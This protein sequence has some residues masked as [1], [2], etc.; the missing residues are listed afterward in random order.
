MKYG[1]SEISRIVGGEHLGKDA[2]I[3]GVFVDSRTGVNDSGALFVALKGARHDG[4]RYIG[5]LYA[6]GI[7][8]F[9]VNR[10]FP[11]G[12]FAEAN[13]V[14]AD[15]TLKAMQNLAADY[16]NSFAFPVLGITGSNGKTCVKEWLYRIFRDLETVAR[17]PKSYNSQTG[18]P[19]SVLMTDADAGLGIFEAG[20]SMPDEMERLERILHPDIGIFT[21]TGDAHQENFKSE[22]HKI[23]EKLQL[24]KSSNLLIYCSDYAALHKTVSESEHPYRTFTWG[25][26][27]ECN[28]RILN[29]RSFPDRT[30]LSIEA[31]DS[32]SGIETAKRYEFEIPF[33]DSASVENAMH[34]IAFALIRGV[35]VGLLS[36]KLQNLTPV[37]MRLELKE[38]VNHCTIINDSYNSDVNSLT[39]ALDFLDG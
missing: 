17:S 16:R 35:D 12:D 34:C 29:R 28:L 20:I 19:L 13:F 8:S 4:H 6:K 38:G 37:A 25:Y 14:V 7:R 26:G 1:L 3:T 5:E 18:V 39:I 23:N 21:N 33:S 24:F 31:R 36:A 30:I 11:A 9:L 27:E 15:D 2:V 22:E 32:D 10:S